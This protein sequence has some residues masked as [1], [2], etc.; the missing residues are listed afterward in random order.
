MIKKPA[1]GGFFIAR[2]RYAYRGYKLGIPDKARAPLSGIV[3]SIAAGDIGELRIEKLRQ[4]AG[5]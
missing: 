3:L 1:S 5:R 2:W 4:I